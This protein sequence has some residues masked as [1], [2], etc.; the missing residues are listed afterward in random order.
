MRK[1]A[2]LLLVLFIASLS[3]GCTS[4]EKPAQ[5]VAT[6]A[7]VYQFTKRICDGTD[8]SVSLLV[9]ENVS[10][11]HDYTL[12]TRQVQ[13]LEAAE[14]VVISGAGLES[15]LGD[16][17]PSDVRIADASQGIPL[18]CA[19]VEHSH[20]THEHNHAQ[21]PHI[22]L[23]PVNAQQMCRNIYNNLSCKYPKYESIFQANLSVL[24]AELAAL[25]QS[26]QQQLAALSGKEL[27][28]FHDGFIYLADTYDL[29]ILY[30]VEEESGSEASA[31]ELIK[32]AKL[33]NAHRLHSIFTEKNGSTSASQ[34]LSAET[35][36]KIYCLDMAMGDTEYFT[37][38]YHNIDTLKEA[39]Q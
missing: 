22:W 25:E 18:L 23:S 39:L 20:T 5:I 8:I 24:L 1:V 3:C 33:I 6:T 34:I 35:G 29:H 2:A 26:G 16:V 15:F 38:M 10:C 14:M 27:I 28:T 9:S 37:A 36:A 11:L 32:I 30:A 17:L 12:Q 21:D 19:E 7:P 13:A 4:S 31:Q